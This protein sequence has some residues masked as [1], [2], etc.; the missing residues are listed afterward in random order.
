MIWCVEDDAGIR[1]IELYALRS[2]GFETRGFEDGSTFWEALQ[3]EKPKLV[4]LDVMLPGIDGVELLRRM[5]ED[6]RLCRV[7]VIMATAKGAEFDKIQALD[8]GADDYLVKPFGMM[9]MVSRIKAVLRRCS[10]APRSLQMGGLVLDP[11]A[12]SVTADGQRVSLTLKEFALL[13]LLLSHPNKA[14]TRE[15]LLMQVWETDYVGETRTVDMHIRTLR[16]KLGDYGNCIHTVRGVGY[17]MG[18]EE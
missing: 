3:R 6:S 13:Q 9:E 2:T 1:D 17:L 7:P 12:H 16:Q 5:R 10:P 4:V 14:F 11:E 15:E 8:L 18:E